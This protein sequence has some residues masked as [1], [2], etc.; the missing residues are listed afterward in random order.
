MKTVG[1][2]DI[3]HGVLEEQTERLD[4][5]RCIF[6]HDVRPV[7]DYDWCFDETNVEEGHKRAEKEYG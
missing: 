6:G 7:D 3:P 1:N 4:Y 2:V 5:D